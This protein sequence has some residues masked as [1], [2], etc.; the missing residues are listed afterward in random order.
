MTDQN[1]QPVVHRRRWRPWQIRCLVALLLIVGFY[2]YS[3]IRQAQAEARLRTLI[4]DIEKDDPH[5]KQGDLEAKYYKLPIS[6]S[7][8]KCIATVPPDYRGWAG[9]DVSSR[10]G[11]LDYHPN[12][13]DYNIRFPEEYYQILK[14]RILEARI[15]PMRQ[16]ILELA[17]EPAGYRLPGS[18]RNSISPIQDAR[19][20]ANKIYDESIFSA[21]QS[22]GEHVILAFQMAMNNARLLEQSPG[23][24]DLLVCLSL[25]NH[26]LA[27]LNHALA[28]CQLPDLQLHQLQ[29]ILD[30][31]TAPMIDKVLK[32]CRA[33][34]FDDWEGAKTDSKKRSEFIKVYTNPPDS[35]G[36]WKEHVQYWIDR[37][38]FEFVL[39]N[40][41]T[42]QAELLEISGQALAL[43]AHQP[44]QVLSYLQQQKINTSNILLK[45]SVDFSEKLVSTHSTY[46]ASVNSLRAA[47]ACERYR[48]SQGKWPSSLDALVPVYLPAIPVD[49]F[50][51][52]PLLYRLLPDGVVIYSVGAN[53]VD[54]QG[55][56]LETSGSPKDRGTRFFNPELRGKKYE[57][58]KP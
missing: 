17:G 46:Q 18:L 28:L 44:N 24:I 31:Q 20:I 15:Q 33:T 23:L 32:C 5:W 16:A 47:L 57:L 9:D 26:G 6:P 43:N 8:L 55:D 42:T 10:I 38:R 2:C 12:G 53:G 41:T 1:S 22:D 27:T 35:K 34:F 56:V 37:V 45:N 52:K 40:L 49:P 13:R 19:R 7:F 29:S 39:G 58:P 54:D 48:L 11:A 4:G 50:S 3:T 25:R 36:T 51:G 14:E 30:Q 21:H